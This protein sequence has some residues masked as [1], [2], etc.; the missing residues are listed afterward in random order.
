[1]ATRG[2]EDPKCFK[3]ILV[4]EG[5]VGKS[6]YIKRLLTGEFEKKYVP[7]LG[8]AVHPLTFYTTRG[9]ITLNIWDTAGQEKFSGL[10]DGYY[11]AADACIGMFDLTSKVT[12]EHL[13]LKQFPGILR[14][15][16]KVRGEIPTVLCGNKCDI[17]EVK[18]SPETR[19]KIAEKYRYFDISAKSNYQYEEP[20][21]CLMRMLV[22]DDT[23]E[24]I[25]GP[26]VA[27]P[28]VEVS[29]L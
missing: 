1:M 5:G 3:V 17:K 9:V 7:T 12:L 8:V 11:I 2:T 13:T 16:K 24:I 14:E 21:L 25:P 23:L 18:V 22:R 19:A 29:R 4:G 26:A 15:V 20:F 27:P 28:E 6:T 10:R